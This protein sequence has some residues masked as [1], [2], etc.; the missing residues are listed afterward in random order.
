M[1]T[2]KQTGLEAESRLASL[3]SSAPQHYEVCILAGGQSSRM[4]TDKSR[5]RLGRRTVVGHISATANAIGLQPR[6]IRADLVPRCG[7]LGG[8]HTALSTS[9]AETILFLSCDMPFLS[10]KLLKRLIG[11]LGR[12]KKALFVQENGRM[13]FPFLLR[14]STLDVVEQQL[15]ARQFSLRK[16]A[17]ALH[18]QTFSL[19][20]GQVHELFN[21]NTPGD[22]KVARE[23]WGSGTR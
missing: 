10:A 2:S 23:R 6:I 16:L 1:R 20:R 14:R 8:V 11:R 19:P 7:P 17:R 9:R 18:A 15:A 22:W 12:R 21:I 3:A 5:L 4:G 13:G